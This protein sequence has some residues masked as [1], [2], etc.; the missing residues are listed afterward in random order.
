MTNTATVSVPSG[1]IDPTPANNSAID[2]DSVTPAATPTADLSVTK[3]NGVTLVSAGTTTTYTVVVSNA[4]PDAANGA[5]VT[6]PAAAGLTKTSVVCA[7]AGGAT[8]PASPTVAQVE[9]GLAIPALP[10]GGSVTLTIGATVTAAS[11]NVTNIATVT[12]PAG[13]IDPTPANNSASDTDNA[14]TTVDLS[15]TMTNGTNSVTAAGSTRYTIVARQRRRERGRGCGRGAG[16]AAGLEQ[17]SLTCAAS[18]G[19]VC[20][21]GPTVAQL[22]TGLSLPTPPPGGIVTFTL[23][24]T[25]TAASGTVSITATMTLPAGVDG[26]EYREQFR[27]RHRFGHRR[28]DRGRPRRHQERRRDRA[29]A[30]QRHHLHDHRD[31]SRGRTR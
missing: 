1:T 22:E 27:D 19:A 16:N 17:K 30:R 14:G 4:G 2:T 6:D 26:H 13:V 24:A 11:G 18:G 31:Q 23:D 5:I 15:L 3:T 12:A 10:F 29:P 8:C 28:A 21:S 20:P 9:A 7:A 25:V